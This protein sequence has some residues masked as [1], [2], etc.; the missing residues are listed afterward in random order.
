MNLH[1]VILIAAACAILSLAGCQS[2]SFLTSQL[3][4]TQTSAPVASFTV[5][6]AQISAGQSLQLTDTSTGTPTAWTWSFGDGSTSSVQNPSHTYSAAGSFTI[7]LTAANAGG[8]SIANRSLTVNSKTLGPISSFTYTPSNPL[9]AGTVAFTDASSGTP[10]SWS[11]SFG[12]GSTS[13]LQN[14]SHIYA[15]KGTYTASL[16]TANS[17]GTA[18]ATQTIAVIAEPSSTGYDMTLTLSDE[19]QATTIAFSGL[20]LITGNLD[21]QSFFPPGKVADYTGFQ[22]LRDTDPDNM[23]HDTD[24]LTRVAYNVIYI[25]TD[26]QIAQLVALAQAQQS[27]VN[28]HGYQRYVLMDAFRRNL[29]GNIPTGSTGLNLNSVKKQSRALYLLDGQIAFDR[30]L[31]YANVY[32]TM[33]SSQIAYLEAM[34][35]KGFN[36]WPNITDAQVAAKMKSLPQG[37]A[38]L[39]MTYA[40][41]IFSWYE[42]SLYA[43]IYF[44]P[45]RHGTYYGGFYIKDAP[46]V[47]VPGYIIDETITNTAGSAL[48]DPSLGYATQAQAAP[49]ANLVNVQRNILYAADT[50]VVSTRAQVAALLRTLMMS[51][52]DAS[53][54]NAKVLA[55]SGTYG[56]LDGEANYD[57]AAAFAALNSTLTAAQQT[58]LETLRRSLLAG[59]YAS[60][61]TFDFTVATTPYLYADPVLNTGVL[62]PY[63]ANSDFMFFDPI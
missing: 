29:D 57:Y 44:C 42:G 10:A 55:L 38:Q 2:A 48:I 13:T 36:S 17:S 25:L 26:S 53:T 51:T 19:A 52:S 46:A 50:N 62:T 45:E 12:D 18:T 58:K 39:V 40:G 15:A 8:S 37:S 41:D 43:D 31:L 60:G 20:A 63:L 4:G 59:T 21:A 47:G 22:Y 5:S 27:M 23:G 3:P 28:E 35:G 9:S 14:P 16:T 34:K 6:A 56:D 1:R 54:V 30:A 11:W 7:T 33:T 61:A 49:I 24:F 32:N